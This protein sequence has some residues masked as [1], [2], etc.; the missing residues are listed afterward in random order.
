MPKWILN[1]VNNRVLHHLVFWF[2][3]FRMNN[4][5]KRIDFNGSSLEILSC[6]TIFSVEMIGFIGFAY[7]VIWYLVP[8]FF[9]PQ[10]YLAFLAT[11]FIAI[12]VL[13]SLLYLFS[14]TDLYAVYGNPKYFGYDNIIEG[15]FNTID[16]LIV[17][18]PIK[19]IR[20]WLRI[21][22]KKEQLETEHTKTE[23]SLLQ[24]QINPYFFFSTLDDLKQMA[25]R[26]DK[27]TANAIYDL[28][29]LMRYM[30]YETSDEKVL[31]SQELKA[32]ETFLDI[33][34]AAFQQKIKLNVNINDSLR[35]MNIHPLILL[36]LVENCFNHSNTCSDKDCFFSL[37]LEAGHEQ[38]NATI[39]HNLSKGS[40]AEGQALLTKRLNLLYKNN[41]ALQFSNEATSTSISLNLPKT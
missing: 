41:Y 27:E 5:F 1:I 25:K 21:K 37:D 35:Q 34:K 18:L 2:V 31:L 22:R 39:K 19:F 23:L 38:I 20:D 32:I 8:R 17:I 10:K 7:F 4:I 13:S 3:A 30:L 33:K 15:F 6:L 36:E 12:L 11:T 28:S 16:F 24:A 29:N 40:S 26:K 9:Y 14:T